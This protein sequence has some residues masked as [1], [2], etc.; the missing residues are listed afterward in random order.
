MEKIIRVENLNYQP[1]FHNFNISIEKNSFT[2][3]SGTNKCGK[4]TLMKILS[5]KIPIDGT[6][7]VDHSYFDPKDKQNHF[8]KIGV[9]LPDENNPFLFQNVYQEL[10]FPLQNLEYSKETIEK[11]IK[12][13]IT[14]FQMEDLIMKNPYEL[15]WTDRNKL[16]IAL[17]VIHHPKILLLED[18]FTRMSEE[19]TFFLLKIIKQLNKEEKMTVVMSTDN[20]K[21]TLESDYLYLLENGNIVIEGNPLLVLQEDKLI[22]RLGLALPFMVDL[23]LKLKFYNLI[24]DVILD[25][26]RMVDCLWK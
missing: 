26:D 24:D 21:E 3:I 14:L 8:E 15:N 25:M 20:L 18:P 9:V 17:A 6:I 11:R 12:E 22:A 23:S 16:L 1:I 7:I 13:I 10:A 4:T 19:D 5:G 2:T